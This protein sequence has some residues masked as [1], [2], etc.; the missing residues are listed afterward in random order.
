M[1]EFTLTH[2][3]LCADLRARMQP[4]GACE[5]RPAAERARCCARSLRRNAAG[6]KRAAF[7]FTGH[8]HCELRHPLLRQD[9]E[10]YRKPRSKFPCRQG[11]ILCSDCDCV[12]QGQRIVAVCTCDL[13]PDKCMPRGVSRQR[14]A[15][16]QARFTH[17]PTADSGLDRPRSQSGVCGQRKI[18]QGW[19]CCLRSWY[20]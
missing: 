7:F 3:R 11:F 8:R 14:K 2:W 18:F 1:C 9:A 4:R 17:L 20:R 16:R 10:P 5:G 6:T 12:L 13:D 15:G 19:R